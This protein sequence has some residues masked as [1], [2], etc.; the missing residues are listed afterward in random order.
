MTGTNDYIFLIF[1]L[2]GVVFSYVEKLSLISKLECEDGGVTKEEHEMFLQ[3]EAEQK[4]EE[5][6][7]E[8]VPDADDLVCS[9]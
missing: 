1:I 2:F 3:G 8:E 6:P 4:E 5:S 9:M 7:K